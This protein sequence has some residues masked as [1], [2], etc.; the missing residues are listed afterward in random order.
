MEG[1]EVGVLAAQFSGATIQ[2]NISIINYQRIWISIIMGIVSGALGLTGFA[3]FGLFLVAFLTSS[4]VVFYQRHF[5]VLDYVTSNWTV[6]L[7]GLSQAGSTY[8]MVWTIVYNL[9]HTF[10]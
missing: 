2:K 7:E 1:E 5:R 9:V 4:L 6:V 10:Q 8:V 3:G